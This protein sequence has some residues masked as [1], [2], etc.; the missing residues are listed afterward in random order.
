MAGQPSDVVA[1]AVGGGQAPTGA[2]PKVVEG[3]GVASPLGADSSA[4]SPLGDGLKTPVGGLP[5]LTPPR[6]GGSLGE[7]PSATC[8][9]D[10]SPAKACLTQQGDDD[11]SSFLKQKCLKCEECVTE[12]TVALT[13]Q[14]K[15]RFHAGADCDC[16]E[17]N[18]NYKSL[19]RRW[20]NK[21]KLQVWFNGVESEERVAWYV[22]QKRV[23]EKLT[24]AEKRAQKR[25]ID[26]SLTSE[27]KTGNWT[28]N[29]IW[30]KPWHIFRRDKLIERMSEHDAKK[31][32]EE[33][34]YG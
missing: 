25:N 21:R 24:Q 18:K 14:A 19:S 2:T 28:G 5:G 15:K 11:D 16:T 32:V 20:K 6:R 12:Q 10:G 30:W 23:S 7:L 3:A 29:R 27:K 4:S 1:M 9:E 34:L 33:M 31:R 8:P 22:S 26:A 17:C 13:T